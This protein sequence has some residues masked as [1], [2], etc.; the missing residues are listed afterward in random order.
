[1]SC[2]YERY[3]LVDPGC[4]EHSVQVEKTDICEVDNCTAKQSVYDTLY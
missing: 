3:V 4:V 2:D 1:M